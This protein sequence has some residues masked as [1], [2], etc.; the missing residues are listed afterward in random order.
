MIVSLDGA[1][2]F[3]GMPPEVCDQIILAVTS[4]EWETCGFKD[5][6]K[7]TEVYPDSSANIVIIDKIPLMGHVTHRS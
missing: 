5:S 2:L 7:S 3:H 6:D 4:C 1:C